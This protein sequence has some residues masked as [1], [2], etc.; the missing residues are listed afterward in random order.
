MRN[1]L[2]ATTSTSRGSLVLRSVSGSCT[3]N[4]RALAAGALVCTPVADAVACVVVA[5]AL[6]AV[7]DDDA[8]DAA[9]YAARVGGGAE[10]VASALIGRVAVAV[11]N[12]TCACAS[13]SLAVG[14]SAEDGV[15]KAW[16]RWRIAVTKYSLANWSARVTV[17]GVCTLPCNMLCSVSTLTCSA[18]MSS[19]FRIRSPT[20]MGGLRY[21]G[22]SCRTRLTSTRSSSSTTKCGGASDTF[23][24]T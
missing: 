8:H 7:P 6:C 12:A 14:A 10:R 18:Y 3:L 4:S 11:T 21:P 15:A 2:D 23:N 13:R 17:T 20:Q 19:T 22:A 24:P 5:A 1:V 9:G 16:K